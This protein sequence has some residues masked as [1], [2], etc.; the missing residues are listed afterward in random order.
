M[1]K[2]EKHQRVL[3]FVKNNEGATIPEIES[4]TDCS[5]A[6][7]NTLIKN[8]YLEIVEQTVKRD[9]LANKQIEHIEK[10]ILNDEQLQAY[11]SVRQAIKEN[12]FEEFYCLE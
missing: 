2:S 3:N 12:R 7:V 4:F 5:R 1:I 8:G 10:L 6:I 11:N 9:P